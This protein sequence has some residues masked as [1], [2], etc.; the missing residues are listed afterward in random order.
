MVLNTGQSFTSRMDVNKVIIRGKVD[1]SLKN[2]FLKELRRFNASAARQTG[3][4]VS[5]S[6]F[7][8]LLLVESIAER[9]KLFAGK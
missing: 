2:Q 3:S 4:K 5:Q 8:E 1:A 6:K 7:L 9:K